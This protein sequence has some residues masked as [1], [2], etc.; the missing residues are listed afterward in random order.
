MLP[1]TRGVTPITDR[2]SARAAEAVASGMNMDSSHSSSPRRIAVAAGA[3]LALIATAAACGS[4]SSGSSGTAGGGGGGTV[5]SSSTSGGGTMVT[6]TEKNFSIAM[7]KTH[8]SPGTYTF[9][10]VNKGPSAH[11]LTISGPGVS[12]PHT[13]TVGPGNPQNLTVTLRSGSYDF[14]CSVPGHKALGMNLEV[15]VGSGGSG[16]GGGGST[17]GSTGGSSSGGSW[18]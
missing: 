9:H 15:M 16:G 6:V 2:Q 3:A 13:Q 10:V 7:S 12:T 17:S 4:S 8:L 5:A 18:G 1:T 11:N 14:Y